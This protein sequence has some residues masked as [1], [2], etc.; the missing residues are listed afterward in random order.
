L[1][2]DESEIAEDQ[3]IAAFGSSYGRGR[4]QI[5]C[6]QDLNFLV[7]KLL[8]DVNRRSALALELSS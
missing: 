7:R 4:R 2:F 1:I 6:G 3:K 5:S 8:I